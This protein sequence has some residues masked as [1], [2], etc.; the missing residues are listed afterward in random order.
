MRCETCVI[1]LMTFRDS[2]PITIPAEALIPE[3]AEMELKLGSD[4]HVL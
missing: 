1:N 2:P 4:R 3:G